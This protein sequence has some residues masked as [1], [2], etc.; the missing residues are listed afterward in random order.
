MADP[1][2]ILDGA[3]LSI[4]NDPRDPHKKTAVLDATFSEAIGTAGMVIRTW[5]VHGEITT[6]KVADALR[7]VPAAAPGAAPGAAPEPAADPDSAGSALQVIRAWAGFAP[8]PVTDADLLALLGLDYPGADIPNWMM[9]ELGVLV[10]K[11]LVTVEEFRT[12]LEYV[13]GAR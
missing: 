9:T 3:S 13:L 4:L 1:G 7:V 6:V 11:G 12:A 10:A 5:N 2:G 8:E